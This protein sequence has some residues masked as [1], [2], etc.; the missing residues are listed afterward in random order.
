M[1]RLILLSTL[2]LGCIPQPVPSGPTCADA[3]NNGRRL[4]A[5]GLVDCEWSAGVPS[6]GASCE[7]VCENAGQHGNP[8]QLGCL[9]R[10][11][12]CGPLVCP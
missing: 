4:Y 7:D 5:S 2:A 1:R 12:E 9:A 11:N 3:C 6:S 8:W 10:T